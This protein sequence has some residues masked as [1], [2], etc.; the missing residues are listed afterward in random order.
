M[1]RPKVNPPFYVM[2]VIAMCLN[3]LPLQ[4][5]AQTYASSS[6][7]NPP[8]TPDPA[9]TPPL[10]FAPGYKKFIIDNAD[11]VATGNAAKA[12]GFLLADY[13]PFSLW[14]IPGPPGQ[15]GLQ[16]TSVE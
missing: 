9:I 12:G 16:K 3:L 4:A 7:A 8:A 6:Q 5:P 11:K 10:N 13:G 14:K 2:L 15:N 1:P